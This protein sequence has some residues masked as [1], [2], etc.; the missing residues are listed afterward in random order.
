MVSTGKEDPYFTALCIEKCG[1]LCCAPWWGIISYQMVKHAGAVA[2]LRA[3]ALKGIKERSAR[4]MSAYV[5]SEKPPRALFSAPAKYNVSV[6]DIKKDGP[7]LKLSILA[8]FAFRCNY[9]TTDNSC[10]IHPSVLGGVDVRPPHCGYMGRLDA[11]PNEK[12]Y[13]RIIHAAASAEGGDAAIKAAIE[14]E[15]GASLK[16]YNEGVDTPEEAADK[17][18][19]AV[20]GWCETDASSATPA[21]SAETPGRNDPCPCGSGR[22]YKKCHGG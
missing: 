9:L 15:K 19:E 8:M 5:T 22:K 1:G 21:K 16:F 4:I 17:I 14:I 12:G 6:R 3:E 20:R 11:K 10:S 18:I 2:A 13:C 7:A